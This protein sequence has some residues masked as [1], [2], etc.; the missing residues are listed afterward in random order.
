MTT[1]SLFACVVAAPIAFFAS[2]LAFSQAFEDFHRCDELVAHPD[3]PNRW[4]DGVL[5]DQ[6]IPG[7]AVKFCAE[8]ANAYPDSPRFHFQYGRALWAAKRYE[9]AVDAFL[10]AEEM[11]YGPAYAYLGDAHF[12]GLGGVE[13]NE[14][15]AVTLY[16]MAA[17]AGFTP[18]EAVL[19]DI[20]ALDE[21]VSAPERERS[22]DPTVPEVPE[23]QAS[24]LQRVQAW[25]ESR[26]SFSDEEM[27]F[28][29]FSRGAR[30][31]A[32]FD[33]DF[34]R[35]ERE[36]Q[37]FLTIY[38]MK[39]NE[40]FSKEINWFDESCSAYFDPDLG[41]G[42]MG[43]IMDSLM[44]SDQQVGQTG[45]MILEQ[46]GQLAQNPNAIIGR[47][48]MIEAE[49]NA[50]T[51]DG[52]VIARHHGCDHPAFERLYKNMARFLR[53]QD[54]AAASGWPGL[55]LQCVAHAVAMG[56]RQD[57]ARGYC[58]CVVEQFSE[59]NMPVAVGEWLSAH[60]DHGDNFAAVMNTQDG[61]RK[62]IGDCLL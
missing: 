24:L 54:P 37:G 23:S 35:L 14:D 2:E 36:D 52:V 30:L 43:D 62:K 56:G 46:I 10:K 31:K 53:G 4:A 19:S 48:A 50:A 44:G 7:P 21:Q 6:I 1:R 57:V 40:Y 25:H 42:V 12:H 22:A 27:N 20:A 29:L 41:P 38:L 55:R 26:D 8:A 5:D 59:G 60:Y 15:F 47:A 16:Q 11:E 33:G 34:E 18:A 13:R 28:Q 3:D 49:Q 45:M 9:A 39:L 32:L 51:K 61:L 58:G 17:E